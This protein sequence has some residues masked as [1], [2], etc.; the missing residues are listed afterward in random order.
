MKVKLLFIFALLLTAVTGAWADDDS[1]SCGTD[2]SYSYVESTHTLT[3]SGTGAMADYDDPSE[4]PWNNYVEEIETVI[5]EDG[6]TGIGNCAFYYCTSLTSVTIPASVTTI[7]DEAFSCCSNIATMTVEA[8]NKVYDSRNSCNAIIKKETN[9]LIAGCKNTI[10]P[11]DVTRIG[12]FAFE[13]CTSLT[14]ITIPAS[15]TSIGDFAFY[16][17]T[18]LTTVTIPASV[19]NIG[20]YA[21]GGCSSLTTVTIGSGVTF[22]GY[23]AFYDCTN[24]TDVYCYANPE[25]LTWDEYG[26]NDFMDDGSTKCHVTDET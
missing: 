9:T 2:V 20:N 10:I 13:G 21:F 15:V 4:R 23:D 22:I 26:C 17:C 16:D 25:E 19:T 6:V 11:D 7:G 14:T 8:G 24:V 12:N 18:G 5:I 1:G 3:I